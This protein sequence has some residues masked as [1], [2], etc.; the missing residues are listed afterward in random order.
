MYLKYEDPDV[1]LDVFKAIEEEDLDNL[2]FYIADGADP[3]LRNDFTNMPLLHK[4]V[5]DGKYAAAAL[6]LELGADPNLRGGPSGYTALHFAAYRPN[7]KMAELLLKNN[8]EKDATAQG[9]ATPLHLA[10]H[11][12]S[13]E[14]VTVLA[15]AGANL[16]AQNARGQTP[17]DMALSQVDESFEFAHEPYFAVA[18]FLEERALGPKIAEMQ[19]DR[20]EQDISVLKRRNPQRFKLKM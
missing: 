14:V 12:G 17:R 9:M 3:D 1:K 11:F 15:D 5:V 7:P 6:L 8:A 13:L 16:A 2:R 18:R 19:R 20:V 10:A 4:A